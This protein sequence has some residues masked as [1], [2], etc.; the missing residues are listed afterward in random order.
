[1]TPPHIS[2]I[3]R[4]ALLL[5]VA[6]I[7]TLFGLSVMRKH[8]EHKALVGEVRS[9]LSES[10]FYRQFYADDA[11]R[12]LLRAMFLLRQAA[13]KGKDPARLLDEALGVRGASL[14]D[15]TS[16]AGDQHLGPAQQLAVASLLA[17]YENCRKLGLLDDDEALTDLGRGDLPEIREGPARGRR[18]EIHT[19]IDA[20]L[21]PGI[22]RVL[23]NLEIG[24]PKTPGH[25]PGDV[26]LAA[27][28]R[29]A[30]DLEN[31]GVIDDGA[32][33]RILAHFDGLAPKPPPPP[34]P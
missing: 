1:M 18:A 26:E 14:L 34:T 20:T 13:A 19:V 23:A 7:A 22:D 3:L 2:D 25:A 27:A 15:R 5:A 33:K 12:T 11:R 10:S 31:A 9:V 30:R 6:G 21:S 24:P 8:R 28:R 4:Y 29:L 32:L 17:N 16:E